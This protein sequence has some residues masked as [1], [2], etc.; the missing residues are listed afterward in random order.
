MDIDGYLLLCGT[1]LLDQV[2]TLADQGRLAEARQLCER[3]VG[4]D[5]LN[6]KG[7][8]L[9]GAIYQEQ[10]ELG[11]AVTAFRHAVYIAPD[12]A[13]GHA[14]LGSLLIR[15]GQ[16]LSGRKSLRT[17]ARLLERL[18]Q[19]EPIPESGGLKAVSMWEIVQMA[20]ESEG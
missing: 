14:M 15:Q 7:H 10:G 16:R 5:R 6:L 18:P 2:E 13:V 8:L 12:L 9:L 4:Q 3:A 11:A 20:L 1:A 17:A 19:H